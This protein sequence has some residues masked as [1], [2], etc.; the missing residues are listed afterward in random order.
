MKTYE[1]D[2]KG[3]FPRINFEQ[4]PPAHLELT[5]AQVE[6][7]LDINAETGQVKNKRTGYFIGEDSE[8]TYIK[9]S[10]DNYST[11]RSHLVWL[12]AHGRW[13]TKGLFV[14]H[15]DMDKHN[16][17]ISNLRE[18]SQA[19]NNEHSFHSMLKV[20][21]KTGELLP[22]GIVL[23]GRKYKFGTAINAAYQ[24][25]VGDTR[26][27]TIINITSNDK[28]FL[29]GVKIFKMNARQQTPDE[30]ISKLVFSEKDQLCIDQLYSG[31][32]KYKNK[33]VEVLG[34]KPEYQQEFELALKEAEH[35][36]QTIFN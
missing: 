32:V 19:E 17:K 2:S 23:L 20:D 9:V 13:P 21:K 27:N 12:K 8:A 24:Y 33:K 3:F 31:Q 10:W 35:Q 26:C 36:L 28:Q 11:T 25:M 4:A 14:D 5:L 1:Q 18:V 15:M 6:E 22:Q 34:V 7:R 30:F 16:D 29:Y